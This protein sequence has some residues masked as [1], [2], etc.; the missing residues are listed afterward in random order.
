MFYTETEIYY[1]L[2]LGI[3]VIRIQ[4]IMLLEL[5]FGCQ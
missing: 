1:Y 3:T 4:Y 2:L 5:M